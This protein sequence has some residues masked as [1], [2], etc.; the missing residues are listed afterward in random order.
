MRGL[1]ESFSL[2]YLSLMIQGEWIETCLRLH[3][4]KSRAYL[5]L[6]IQ[7]EWIETSELSH[8]FI[9]DNQSLSDDTG[10]VD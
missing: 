8:S 5:S 10:R 2:P 3:K 7:G 4:P 6:M 9:T 1:I